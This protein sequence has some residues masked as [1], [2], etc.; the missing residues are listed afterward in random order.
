MSK[1]ID[2][3][4]LACPQPVILTKKALDQMT[5]GRMTTIVD[6]PVAKENVTK[7]AVSCGCTVESEEKAGLFYLHITKGADSETGQAGIV[8]Q[9][10][11]E[12]GSMVYVITQD[13]LGHGSKELGTVLMKSFLYTLLET[14]PLPGKLLFM[15]SGVLLTVK[16]SPLLEY[17]NG[18]AAEGVEILSCGTCLDYYKLKEELAVGSVTNMYTIVESMSAG[19]R[20]VTL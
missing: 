19:S 8:E 4:G 9:E 3:R 14:R 11:S 6:N 1:E 17:L 7:L 16:S 12:K 18:L 15:N 13:T 2:A 10:T 20:V 5:A